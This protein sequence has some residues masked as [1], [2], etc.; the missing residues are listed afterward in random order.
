MWA[1][2]PTSNWKR[3]AALTALG[4]VPGKASMSTLHL[5]LI[6]VFQR[7]IACAD[8]VLLNKIDLAS[9]NVS[10]VSDRIR[11]INPAAP[12]F[13]T[14]RGE[15][16]LAN[17]IGIGAYSHS[18][19]K[20]RL[21]SADVHNGGPNSNMAHYELRGISS[22]KITCPALTERQL[23]KL[24][25]WIRSVLWEKAVPSGASLD[26]SEILVL[27]CKGVFTTVGGDR[28]VLQGVRE[29][30]EVSKVEETVSDVEGLPAEGKIVLIGKG[31]G[32]AIRSSLEGILW[33]KF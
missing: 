32:P 3:T 28:Y 19:D 1:N 22:V 33:S 18:I 31:L 23:E 29:L 7:Q 21:V 14:V 4:K 25:E 12:I 13:H 8:V 11:Q 2:L 9:G 24:D 6:W 17:L 5:R 30:Y 27:R 16:D 15:V 20:M 26:N 10:S